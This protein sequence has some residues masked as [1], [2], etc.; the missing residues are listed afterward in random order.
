M[1]I[2]F[3]G[4]YQ[5]EKKRYSYERGTFLWNGRSTPKTTLKEVS[6]LADYFSLYANPDYEGCI[7]LVE[8][9]QPN[10]AGS[11][12]SVCKSDGF[13]DDYVE[14]LRNPRNF[15]HTNGWKRAKAAFEAASPGWWERLLGNQDAEYEK[16]GEFWSAAQA[17]M[18]ERS[19]S[20]EVPTTTQLVQDSIYETIEDRISDVKS[21]AKAVDPRTYLPDLGPYAEVAKWATVAGGLYLVY[22]ALQPQKKA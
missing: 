8:K 21:V 19:A 17:W 20:S 7:S 5:L 2:D 13:W 6:R 1:G 14:T 4:V 11:A 3:L 10:Q 22:K 12:S 15:V 18:I 16:N 9:H